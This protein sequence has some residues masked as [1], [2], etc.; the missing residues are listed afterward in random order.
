MAAP[1]DTGAVTA[2]TGAQAPPPTTATATTV[3][4]CAPS[5]YTIAPGDVPLTVAKKFDT[6]LDAL[7]QANADNAGYAKFYVGAVIKI[8][9][10][11]TG[12]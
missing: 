10:K 11:T 3:D 7:N 9:G 1:V 2:N 6:T 5:D 4:T 12:C 8:P